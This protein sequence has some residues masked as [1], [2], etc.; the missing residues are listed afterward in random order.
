TAETSI[1]EQQFKK[2]QEQLMQLSTAYYNIYNSKCWKLTKPIRLILDSV[3][4][5][6]YTILKDISHFTALFEK[7]VRYLKHFGIRATGKKIEYK[8]F[9]H[10]RIKKRPFSPVVNNLIEDCKDKVETGKSVSIIIPTKNAGEEY[11]LLLKNL[12]NQNGFSEIEIVVVDSGSTD[13]TVEISRKYGATVIK[14][15]PEEFSHSYSRNIGAEKATKEYL[16]VMTQDALPTSEY[17]LYH[18]YRT[19]ENNPKVAAVSCAEYPRV[20]ADLYHRV[21]AWNHYKYLG[22]INSDVIMSM[23]NSN[24]P[25]L[26]RQNGQLSDITCFIERDTLLKY[27]YR[28]NF[29]ED[30]DLGMRLITD[31]YKLAFLGN[32]VSIHSH[33]RASFYY[34]KRRFVELVTLKKIFPDQE[35]ISYRFEQV[36]K[37]TVFLCYHINI[38]AEEYMQEYITSDLKAF[39]EKF[40]KRYREIRI[41]CF[42]TVKLIEKVDLSNKID[43]QTVEFLADCFKQY[44]EIVI[45]NDERYSGLMIDAMEGYFNVVFDFMDSCYE[46]IDLEIV[47]EFFECVF[48]IYT[49][50]I[51]TFFAYS[52]LSNEY[53]S[54]K[55]NNFYKSI[56]EGV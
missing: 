47:S 15:K 49:S 34:L 7:A 17:W 48:K 5:V 22:V 37:E 45:S 27:R 41:N 20:D 1:I 38:L 46:V 21:F 10:K 32:E 3:K 6:F 43:T 54:I 25:I 13:N 11:E 36:I 31:G 12:I 30:L 28:G 42:P 39:R 35:V 2:I 23:P 29:A 44:R 52:Y 26:L 16:C 51:G 4:F 56:G 18:L 9:R 55:H 19:M 53:D 14:I 40:I 50:A 8:L 33:N 24:D